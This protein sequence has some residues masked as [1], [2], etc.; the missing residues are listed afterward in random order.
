MDKRCGCG[1]RGAECGRRGGTRAEIE[2]PRDGK[3][4][5]GP[6]PGPATDQY[7]AQAGGR[8]FRASESVVRRSRSPPLHVG[9]S[10]P[11]ARRVSSGPSWFPASR[12]PHS[13]PPR[14]R[15]SKVRTATLVAFVV[16]LAAPVGA[17]NPITP[18]KGIGKKLGKG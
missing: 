10:E 1:V 4:F 11:A 7:V 9:H 2:I 3:G 14:H 12:T 18:M 5:D 17:Q 15:M 13:S 8:R 16:A 6:Q